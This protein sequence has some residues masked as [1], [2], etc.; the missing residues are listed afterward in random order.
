[1]RATPQW[2]ISLDGGLRDLAMAEIEKVNFHPETE[3]KRL[4][5]MV[6]TRGDWCILANASGVFLFR[7]FFIRILVPCIQ[8]MH[9]I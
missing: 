6:R 1:M 8:I 7:S 2:F 9:I 4:K 3:K 5:E